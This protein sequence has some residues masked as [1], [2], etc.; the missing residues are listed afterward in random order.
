V[1]AHSFRCAVPVS[2]GVVHLPARPSRTNFGCR[3]TTRCSWRALRQRTP[4]RR[5]APSLAIRKRGLCIATLCPQLSASRYAAL[6]LL[7]S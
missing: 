1:L 6:A 3:L 4:V 5:L 7:L 2:I